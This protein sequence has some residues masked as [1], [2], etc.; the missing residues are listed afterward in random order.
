MVVV[1]MMTSV[2]PVQRSEDRCGAAEYSRLVRGVLSRRRMISS[3]A[4]YS[5]FYSLSVVDII[6]AALF[7]IKIDKTIQPV[8]PL[9]T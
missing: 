5:T 1:A 6:P 3:G 4:Q 9:F 8:L 7:W 2:S